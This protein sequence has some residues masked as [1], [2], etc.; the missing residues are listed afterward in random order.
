LKFAHTYILAGGRSR[1][2]GSDKALAEVDG[3]PLILHV[4]NAA[5][6]V[7][8]SV[9]VIADAMGKYDRIGLPTIVDD[10]PG[11]GPL[12]GLATALAAAP[13]HAHVLLLSC[14][15]LGLQKHW[16]EQLLE[17]DERASAALFATDPLQPLLARY[18]PRLQDELARQ[19]NDGQR[20][21]TRF[22][23]SIDPLLLPPPPDWASLINVNFE[24]DIARAE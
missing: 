24:T 2:F 15:L 22:V 11:L 13:E 20:A 21:I 12:G 17:A 19:M 14:D 23:S 8:E 5:A 10:L 6:E 18:N 3:I 7:S 16:L 1:R 4:A 9:T